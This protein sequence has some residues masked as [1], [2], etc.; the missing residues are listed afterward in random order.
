MLHN[1]GSL[2]KKEPLILF[3]TPEQTLVRK[4]KRKEF[5]VQK[6]I[7]RAGSGGRELT[8]LKDLHLERQKGWAQGAKA[9]G[10]ARHI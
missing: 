6:K 3:G 9:G 1:I 10:A 8:G 7:K 5:N 2:L 4:E